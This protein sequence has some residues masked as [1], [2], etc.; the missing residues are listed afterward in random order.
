MSRRRHAATA[1]A[2]LVLALG[3]GCAKKPVTL[4]SPGAP[5]FADFIYPAGPATLEEVAEAD[6]LLHVIDASAPDRERRM[7][8]VAAVL[9]E[10]GAQRVPCIDVFNKCDQLDAGER[11]RIAALYPRAVCVS[12]L[13]GEGRDE[14]IAAMETKLALDTATVTFQFDPH[15]PMDRVHIANLYRFGRILRHVTSDTAVVV[16]AEL[17]RRLLGRF[18]REV[19]PV[20]PELAPRRARA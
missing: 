16:E 18:Q 4:P 7:A 2:V 15:D 8:A 5:R 3:A 19:A 14:V 9:E 6:L 17:P 10:V 20:S 13:T 11:A 1:I 12:A